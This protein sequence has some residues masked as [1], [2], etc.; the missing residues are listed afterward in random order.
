[1][2][3]LQKNR[4][5]FYFTYRYK[6]VC[7]NQ[8]KKLK[9]KLKSFYQKKHNLFTLTKISL[10]ISLCIKQFSLNNKKTHVG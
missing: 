3:T 6:V 4:D 1:M 5:K 2:M 10:S 9:V 8:I 7:N